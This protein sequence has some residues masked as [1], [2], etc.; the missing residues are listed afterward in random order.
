[1]EKTISRATGPQH[2]PP[3]S[4]KQQQQQQQRG[5]E[6]YNSEPSEDSSQLI[7]LSFMGAN[8]PLP[9]ERMAGKQQQQLRQQQQLPGQSNDE[10]L[11]RFACKLL[12]LIVDRLESLPYG[13]RWITNVLVQLSSA[14][15]ADINNNNNT[16]NNN[17]NN[18]NSNSYEKKKQMVLNVVFETFLIPA[19]LRPEQYGIVEGYRIGHR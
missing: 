19:I 11:Q 8:A 5:G 17:N 4:S 16:N 6:A 2:P 10:P 12:T 9:T 13:I 7:Y 15:T 18:N 1:M 14:K 3:S